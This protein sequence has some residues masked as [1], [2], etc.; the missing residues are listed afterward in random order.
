M[1]ITSDIKNTAAKYF[2]LKIFIITFLIM[3]AMTTV[4]NFIMGA[5]IDYASITPASVGVLVFFWIV[6]SASFTFLTRWQIRSNYDQPMQR[7]AK[8]TKAVAGGDFSIYVRPAHTAEKADYL[9]IMIEDFNKMVAE[10]GSIETLKT[11]FFS[12][13]SH[14][15][16]TPLSVIQNYAELL[17][18]ECLPNERRM[19]YAMAIMQYTKKLSG[20]I[21]NILKL[22]RL[23]QQQILPTPES[24]D[25]CAQLGGCALQFEDIWEKKGIIFEAELEDCAAITAD[26][27]LL[28]LVWNN[29]LSNAIKFTGK[30]G[31]VTLTQTSA[32][33]EIIVTVADTGCGMDEETLK[34]IYDK[35][36]QGDTSHATE[37]N[38][39]GL[40]LSLRVLQ[41]TGGS[42]S[43]KS[44]LGE[45]TAFTV[46]L[47]VGHTGNTHF[48]KGAD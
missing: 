7:L 31:S 33:D 35:F 41:L 12:N 23:E 36:Y 22:N 4:Q 45:G 2:P 32:A 42:I 15:I 43:V 1:K 8:A 39:L 40:S 3:A 16:K 24:Y 38:G 9:D 14:E 25:L 48:N 29:L 19:E 34:H 20:L 37:G 21:T 5:H 11:E 13:V 27:S 17:Q 30:G 18:S 10:L 47:P 26:E 28:G 6:L 44:A 46:R